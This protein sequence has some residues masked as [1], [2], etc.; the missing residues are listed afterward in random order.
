MNYRN[1]SYTPTEWEDRSIDENTGEVL[2]EGTPV[3]EVR[4]GNIET[5]MLLSHL[6]IG[7]LAILLAQQTGVNSKEIQKFKKQRILQGQATLTNT[8]QSGYFRAS[9]PFATI[10][11]TGYP[12][13]NAPNY[14]VLLEVLSADDL[15]RVGQLTAYEKTQN[16]FKVS[17]TGSAK[18]VSFLW[19][20][21]NPNV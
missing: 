7:A 5:G 12:Q 14:T 2:V 13:L 6:D 15:G 8:D 19:T 10:A 4:L 11:L 18:T 21:I 17:M 1:S 9:D 20:V 3:D 16:G